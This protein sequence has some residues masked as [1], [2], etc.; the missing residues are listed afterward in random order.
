MRR[1]ATIFLQT[2]IVQNS[3]CEREVQHGGIYFAR[4]RNP[5]L[6]RIKDNVPII[7]SVTLIVPCRG[8][9]S[10]AETESHFRRLDVKPTNV[11]V[12]GAVNFGPMKLGTADEQVN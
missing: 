10:A 11:E 8:R 5:F 9:R 6:G 3:L 2:F 7:R 4:Q 12:V 1:L